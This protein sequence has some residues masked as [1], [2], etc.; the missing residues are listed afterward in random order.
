MSTTQKPR[1]NHRQ[2]AERLNCTP[3]AVRSWTLQGCPQ[4]HI[5]RLVR[6]YEDDVVQWLADREARRR[7]QLFSRP[8]RS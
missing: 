8:E 6:F 5:G 4:Q 3:A 1:L 7:A 2:L